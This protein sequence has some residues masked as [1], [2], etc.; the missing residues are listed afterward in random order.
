MFLSLNFMNYDLGVIEVL[1]YLILCI[2]VKFQ[3]KN[4]FLFKL[5]VYYCGG[6]YGNF[7][8][9]IWNLGEAIF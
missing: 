4:L 8:E 5:Y 3:V 9:I 2:Y 7:I 6:I 1:E